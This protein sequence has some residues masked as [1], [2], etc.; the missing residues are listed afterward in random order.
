MYLGIG[1]TQLSLKEAKE[2]Y[3]QCNL[4]FAAPE[5]PAENDGTLPADRES[6]KVEEPGE[7]S[8]PPDRPTSKGS[9]PRDRV[10]TN[11]P[12][13]S[14][15]SS[16]IGTTATGIPLYMGPRGGIYHYSKS[17]KKVYQRK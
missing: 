17:G 3:E 10:S 12:P 15:T 2:Q 11:N 7:R 9:L 5:K 6:T 13:P 4:C 1:Q 16:S 14:S 8:D